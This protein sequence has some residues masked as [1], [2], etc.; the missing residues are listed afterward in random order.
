MLQI[1]VCE[2]DGTLDSEVYEL[3]LYLCDFDLCSLFPCDDGVCQPYQCITTLGLWK[4]QKC[5]YSSLRMKFGKVL[6]LVH[7]GVALIQSL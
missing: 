7:C 3:G 2:F 4:A 5:I 1:K 6:C